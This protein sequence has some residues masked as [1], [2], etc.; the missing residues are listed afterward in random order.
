MLKRRHK[1][2]A[3][4]RYLIY[5]ILR[6]NYDR[7][8]ILP[9]ALCNMFQMSISNLWEE[10]VGS[11]QMTCK[12]ATFLENRSKNLFPIENWGSATTQTR[13]LVSF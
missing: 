3:T 4:F 8:A 7:V 6:W 2:V 9:A 12:A 1:L 5:F 10:N 13:E 11:Q